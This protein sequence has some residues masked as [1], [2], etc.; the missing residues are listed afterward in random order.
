MTRA[1]DLSNDEAN[2]GGATPPFVAGKN[3][4]IGGGFDVWQR[5]TTFTP[6]GTYTADRWRMDTG[7]TLTVS[8]QTTGVPAGSRYCMRVAFGSTTYSD[9]ST[10]IETAN[11]IPLQGKT[12]TVQ[13]KL[14][15]NASFVGNLSF[16]L[17]KSASVD[18]AYGAT[19]TTIAT[20]TAANAD[21]PTG[22][23]VS[24]WYTL[25]YTATIPNDGTANSLRIIGGVLAT[26]SSGAY[27]ELAQVQLEI[28]NVL[29]PFSRA[30]GSIGGETALCQRYFYNINFQE[31]TRSVYNIIGNGFAQN[32]T[33]GYIIVT[34]PVSMRI[35]PSPTLTYAGPFV[36][37]D[38]T[39]AYSVSAITLNQSGANSCLLNATTTGLTALRPLII[40]ANGSAAARL[41]FSAEL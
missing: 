20:G 7:G 8:Q 23:G 10:S 3:F 34:F 12:I 29:T 4:V 16:T 32:T 9:L 39:L 37:D 14:R 35:A 15:R 21:L 31:T 26:Q 40:Y 2:N 1:R 28:G 24:D 22:T 17:Q 38:G 11:V 13:I 30:G 18:A 5:G 25:S 27:W 6:N 33:N 36:L 41:S 19:W